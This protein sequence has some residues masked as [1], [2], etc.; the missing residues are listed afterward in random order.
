MSNPKWRLFGLVLATLA[1][2]ALF[3]G[4]AV[5]QASAAY[6]VWGTGQETSSTE[7]N[8]GVVIGQGSNVIGNV[9]SVGDIHVNGSGWITGNADTASQFAGV[10]PAHVTG[11]LTE[12]D[13]GISP[14]P[15][16]AVAAIPPVDTAGAS[17][18]NGGSFTF[19][20]GLS[21]GAVSGGGGCDLLFP[22]PGNYYIDRLT[23]AN[24]GTI[25]I[26]ASGPVNIFVKQ[27]LHVGSG[28]RCPSSRWIRRERL[29]GVPVGGHGRH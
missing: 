17:L 7:Y 1:A 5:V 3:A 26:N 29:L 23:L 11:T 20:P 13:A 12:N 19:T 24:G 8:P 15:F 22:S 2:M 21:Y 16:P 25:N 6:L 9:G 27:Y 14:P 18:G 28:H 4:P 10:S